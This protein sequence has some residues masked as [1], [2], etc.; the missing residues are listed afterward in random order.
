MARRLRQDA[1]DVEKILWRAL[2]ERLDPWKFRR[3]HPIGLRIADFACPARKLIIELD[4]GQHAERTTADNRRSAELAHRG[5]RIIRF[6]N[7]EVLDNLDGVLETIRRALEAPP[8]LPTSPPQGG[9]EEQT[10]MIGAGSQT[11]GRRKR[12]VNA[13]APTGGEDGPHAV[14]GEGDAAISIDQIAV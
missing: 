6:W 9:G 2:R 4:G 12:C 3:Q 10:I 11:A 5:Y 13:I 14:D 1:T 7:N 8:P